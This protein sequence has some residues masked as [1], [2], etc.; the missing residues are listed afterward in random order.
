MKTRLVRGNE[1]TA[2]WLRKKCPIPGEE[3]D[4]YI[5]VLLSPGEKITT[6]AHKR[7]T[8]LFYPEDADPVTITPK[9]GTVLYLPVDTFHSVAPVE[10]ARLSVAMLVLDDGKERQNVADW[11]TE[12]YPDSDAGSTG[13]S[14]DGRESGT[15]TGPPAST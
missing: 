10:R 4:K 7:H 15:A 12:H 2:E 11:I 9:A 14:S 3:W 1:S 8:V 5:A 6:H 13:G